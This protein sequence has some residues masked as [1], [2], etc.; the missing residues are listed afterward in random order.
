MLESPSAASTSAVAVAVEACAAGGGS[1]AHPCPYQ[2]GP[3]AMW[4]E[5]GPWALHLLA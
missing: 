5:A 1:G 3:F 2:V 4:E